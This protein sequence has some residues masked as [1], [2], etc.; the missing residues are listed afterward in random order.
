MFASIT[1]PSD[2]TFLKSILDK[3][4]PFQL[5]LIKVTSIN[6]TTLFEFCKTSFKT[7]KS[8]F[9]KFLK[10]NIVVN[11][12]FNWR[13]IIQNSTFYNGEIFDFTYH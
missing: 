13:K 7:I 6:L 1:I 11:K 3:L 2:L 5:T 12:S 9:L 10:T 4:S 8:L